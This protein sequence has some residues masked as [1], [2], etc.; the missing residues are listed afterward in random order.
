MISMRLLR[1]FDGALDQYS[2]FEEGEGD[3]GDVTEWLGMGCDK[4][5]KAKDETEVL[6][7][8]NWKMEW[9]LSK[10]VKLNRIN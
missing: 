7:L 8:N 6:G 1:I 4:Q 5:G 2:N 10:W 3:C 9:H